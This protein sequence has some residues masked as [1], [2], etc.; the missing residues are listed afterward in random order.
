MKRT[1]FFLLLVV[2]CVNANAQTQQG[3]VKTRGRLVDGQIVAG[4]R[5]AG[6]TITLN[7]G[8]TIVSDNQGRFYFEVPKA[9]SFS[10][11]SATKPGYT[12]VD[13]EYTKRIF[14]YSED[15]PFIVVL[16][17]ENQRQSDIS[18]TIRKMRRTLTAQLQERKGE[19]E[20]LKAQ[21]KLTETEYQKCLQELYD[22]QLKSEQ[23]VEEMAERYASIDY[24][25]LDE[26]NR[27]VQM[28]IE[29]GELQKA[30]YMICS[31]GNLEQRMT[32]LHNMG[33]QTMKACEELVQDLYC[34]VYLYIGANN[35]NEANETIDK[36]IALMPN[37]ANFYDTKDEILLMQGKN[38]DALE[39]WK[40]VLELNPDFLKE[41]PDGTNLSNGLKKLGLIE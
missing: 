27:Q 11:V 33:T 30:D 18:A 14:S 3:I 22:N 35:F 12:L 8:D 2:F 25:Q 24:D 4:E 36:A 1:V 28:Y 13:S 29:E 37:N 41:Y 17:D 10:L 26:F 40:K 9:K 21:N 19:I 32:E 15:N 20:E 16:E 6:V 5:L 31:K 38:E 39:M 23:L 34:I 7:Y